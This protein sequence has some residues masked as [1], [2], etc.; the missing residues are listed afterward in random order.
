MRKQQ[1]LTAVAVAKLKPRAARV[2]IPDG[3]AK[4]LALAIQPSGAKSWIMRFRRPDGRPGSLT[5]GPYDS[6]QATA[7]SSPVLGAPLTLAGARALSAEIHRQ[8]ATGRD[9]VADY[10]AAKE[11][12]RQQ[13][14]SVTAD[15]SFGAAARAF[16]E[17]HARPN[18]RRW[19]ET[20]KILGLDY[21][22]RGEATLRKGG[23][24]ARW[25][26]KPLA[27]ID[28]GAIYTL[29]DEAKRRGIPGR[30]RRNT[31]ASDP[32]GRAMARTL[33]KMFDWLLEHRKIETNPTL[34]VYC[35]PPPAARDR[36]LTNA[37][38]RFFWQACDV[39]G[40]PFGK[41]FR[42]LLL[43]GARLNEASR[44]TYAELQNEGAA[45]LLP[46]ARAKNKRPHLVPLS[47]LARAQIGTGTGYVFTTNGRTPISGF[48]KTKARLD[49]AM[50][51]ANVEIAPW[52]LH[53]LRRTAA[54]GMAEIGVEPHI[55]E[56]ALNHV[57]GAKAGVAGIYNR[58]HYAEE[59]RAALERWGAHVQSISS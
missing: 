6:T 24:A 17:E 12:Q 58:A 50:V 46:A 19:E 26:A 4:G 32:R 2:E 49:A 16:I 22:I 7:A 1:Q 10:N 21:S 13:T 5:L 9:V 47:A 11:R 15:D 55:I 14:A 53:D 28:S 54:T 37:E 20:A 30:D 44:M 35:P 56:A 43:T 52:V 27:E 41:L 42:F 33:S 3:G 29:V 8:R 23:L 45:W 34:G 18:T 40:S 39:V 36:V 59:K 51:A 38:I 31:G 25:Q 48:S 57:S